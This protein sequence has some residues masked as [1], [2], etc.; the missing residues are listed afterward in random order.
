[1]VELVGGHA[2]VDIFVVIGHLD[3]AGELDVVVL[4]I[5]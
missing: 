3:V 5:S 4:E 1:M 2:L